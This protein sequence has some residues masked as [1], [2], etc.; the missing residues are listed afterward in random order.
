LIKYNAIVVPGL[1]FR[2][3][4]TP[5]TSR[6][7]FFQFAI[8]AVILLEIFLNLFLLLSGSYVNIDYIYQI[9]RNLRMMVG[10]G[11]FY[12]PGL[13]LAV[14]IVLAILGYKSNDQFMRASVWF[15]GMIAVM[16]IALNF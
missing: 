4:A 5:Q 11:I 13:A 15:A 14:P 8:R 6:K 7:Y 1:Y 12:P 9:L 2:G 16:I 10:S 3:N